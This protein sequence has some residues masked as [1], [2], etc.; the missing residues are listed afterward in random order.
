MSNVLYAE[1]T[2]AGFRD[3]LRACPIAYLPLGT[4]EWHGEH[5]PLGTDALL[6]YEFFIPL[7]RKVGG[8]VLPLVFMGPDGVTGEG[9]RA[10]YGMDAWTGEKDAGRKLREPAPLEGS[11]YWMPDDLFS[12]M[13]EAIF[14][15]LRRAGFK[16][17]VIHG[18][19]PSVGALIKEAGEAQILHGLRLFNCWGYSQDGQ[20]RAVAPL[21]EAAT[22]ITGGHG[23]SDETA[24]IL[25]L[26]PELAR[27]DLLPK[28]PSDWPI[29]VGGQDPRLH[30]SREK[31]LKMTEIAMDWMV[32]QLDEY[33]ASGNL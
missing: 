15:Q 20:W 10:L 25:A 13:A 32:K 6:A 17:V 5:L 30:A 31:G 19:G 23:G 9:D 2:P 7:A 14:R 27:M 4:L 16:A 3:R 12:R 33:L 24:G 11:A 1:L 26:R 28:N 22:G 18:H 29:G 21:V 8:I